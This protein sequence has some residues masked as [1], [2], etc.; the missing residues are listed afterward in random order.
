MSMNQT[1]NIDHIIPL[2]CGGKTEKGNLQLTHKEC[3]SKKG[4]SGVY[5]K[6]EVFKGLHSINW[7]LLN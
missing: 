2:S 6:D 1:I 7:K 4:N 3:N 5:Y